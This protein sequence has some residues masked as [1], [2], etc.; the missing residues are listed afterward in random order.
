MKKFIYLFNLLFLLQCQLTNEFYLKPSRVRGKEAKEILQN[1][2]ASFFVKDITDSNS[3]SL[4]ADFLMPTLAKI[5]DD[6]IYKRRD[7]ENCA[8]R[9]FLIGIAI[10]QPSIVYNRT[11][12]AN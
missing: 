12:R 10:D 5:Q 7:V 6:G 4:A 9:I 1:R 11:K 8:T 2:L 3:E